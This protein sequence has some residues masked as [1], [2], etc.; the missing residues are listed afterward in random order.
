MM[1]NDKPTRIKLS[2]KKGFNLQKVSRRLNGLPAVNCARPS[3]YG[4]P[5]TVHKPGNNPH[6]DMADAQQGVC[7]SRA[8]A[9]KRFKNNLR[10]NLSFQFEIR[11]EL[12]EK[13]LACWCPLDE[14]CHCDVLLEIA[15]GKMV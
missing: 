3:R 8:A 15:N 6:E 10:G 13:N 12:K 1:K 2:R 4:N 11:R 9:V 14:P 7:F 5:F